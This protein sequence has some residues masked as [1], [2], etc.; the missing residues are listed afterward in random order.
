LERLTWAKEIVLVDSFSTDE[1][2]EIARKFPRTRLVQRAFDDHTSQWNFALEQVRTDWVLSLDADYV[3]SPELISEIA[4]LPGPSPVVAYYARFRYCVSGR[5]LRATLYPPR[6][7]LFHRGHSHYVNDG[8]TQ[9]LAV[10]GASA[11]LQGTIDHDDRKPLD[12]W[13]AE[14]NRYATVEA[15]HLLKTPPERLKRADRLRLRIVI[16][17]WLVFLYVAFVRGVVLDG[18]PGWSY[19][20]QRTL[21][22]IM[23]SLRLLEEKLK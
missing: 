21:A 8:H 2:L 11:F 20:F 22:E 6:A 1:T 5:P 13:L 14:Q 7:V 12:R 9:L 16:A 19:I 15:R 10:N 23:L 18:W 17:P 4:T 3:L